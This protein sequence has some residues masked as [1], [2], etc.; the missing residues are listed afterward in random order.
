MTGVTFDLPPAV[1][2]QIAQRAAELVGKVPA[3][4]GRLPG[5]WLRGAKAIAEY[6]DAPVSRVNSLSSA[7]RIPVEKDGSALVAHTDDLDLWI[8]NGGGKRP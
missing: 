8:R 3:E 7:G 5:R 6:I 1:I 4:E 2:E